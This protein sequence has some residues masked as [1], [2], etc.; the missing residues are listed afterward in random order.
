MKAGNI[1]EVSSTPEGVEEAD[2]NYDDFKSLPDDV[3]AD[4][5]DDIDDNDN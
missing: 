3:E 1:S 5:N 4:D 2:D